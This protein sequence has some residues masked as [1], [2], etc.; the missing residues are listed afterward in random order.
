MNT[1][2]L[3]PVITKTQ[4]RQSGSRIRGITDRDE[5][6]VQTKRCVGSFQFS[7][8]TYD[9]TAVRALIFDGRV[10][11]VEQVAVNAVPARDHTRRRTVL[12]PNATQMMPSQ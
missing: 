7:T 5:R 4:K 2:R 11:Y 8:G 1:I 12:A 9:D 3:V 10:S 6:D